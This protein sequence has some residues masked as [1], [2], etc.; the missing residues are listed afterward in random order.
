LEGRGCETDEV[1]QN[2]FE[3]AENELK[4]ICGYDYV[5]FNKDLENGR[6][7]LIRFMLLQKC[8]EAVCK[9]KLNKLLRKYK[10]KE[11]LN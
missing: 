7:Q 5:I 4:R 9:L 11:I 6:N 1:I 10:C 2:R 8:R 3:Q